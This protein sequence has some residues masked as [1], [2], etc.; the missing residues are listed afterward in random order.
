MELFVKPLLL[1]L[2]IVVGNKFSNDAE[3]T[4]IS[5]EEAIPE[6]HLGMDIG[7]KSIE[8]FKT[9]CA[10]ASTIFWN[11]PLGVVEFSQFAKGT[12]AIAQSLAEIES[13]SIVGGGDSIAAINTMG[14]QHG[15]SHLSTGGGATIEYIEFGTLPGIE[16]LSPSPCLQA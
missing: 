14:L 2:D 6:G 1:P 10:E 13:L 15:F 7:P 5:S 8:R 12:H 3:R 4:I 9:F 11:G 16:A